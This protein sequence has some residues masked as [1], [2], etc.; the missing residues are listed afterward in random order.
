M[1]NAEKKEMLVRFFIQSVCIM[2]GITLAFAGTSDVVDTAI[3]KRF[4]CL[5]LASGF[6]TLSIHDIVCL[7]IKFTTSK[8]PM[9]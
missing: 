8:N 3:W 2:A 6:F 1:K 7:A 9:P 5:A 4:L